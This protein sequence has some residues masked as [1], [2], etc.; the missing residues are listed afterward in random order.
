[1]SL[2][3]DEIGADLIHNIFITE[4]GEEVMQ[5]TNEFYEQ[6]K[7]TELSDAVLTTFDTQFNEFWETFPTSDKY[8]GYPHTRVLRSDKERCKKYYKK[9]LEEASHEDIIKALVYEIKMREKN[10]INNFKSSFSDFK[11]MKA[12]STWL[13]QK[14]YNIYIQLMKED[15]VEK[16]D[17]FSEDV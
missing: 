2:Y 1:M 5:T 16:K 15:T 11:F 6:I 8:Q 7:N 10:S 14:E 13:H 17:V 12:S 3:D 9:A 4:K